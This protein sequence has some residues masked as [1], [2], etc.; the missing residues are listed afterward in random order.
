[1]KH[2]ILKSLTVIIIILSLLTSGAAYALGEVVYTNTQKLADNL[3]YRNTISWHPTLGRTESFAI[4]MTG[5][6]DAYPIVMNGETVFGTNR[7]SA[8]VE[9]AE[10]MGK[11]VLAAV[12]ADFFFPQ[13]GGVPLGIVIEDGEYKSSP[14]GRNAVVFGYQG[15]VVILEAP[16][17]EISLYNNGGSEEAENAGQTAELIHFNKPRTDHGG[18]MLYSEAFSNT[19]TRTTTPGWFIRFRILEGTPSVSGVM[20]L[21]VTEKLTSED[22]I[23]IGEGNMVLTAADENNIGF[24]FEKFAVGDIVTLSTTTND[25]RLANAQYATGGGDVLVSRGVKADSSGW[26]P[27]LLPR[28]PRTAFG[29]RAD[30]SVVSFVVD[31]RNSVHSV[32]LTLDELADE[33]LRQGC[34][35]AVNFDGG[36]SS[37]LSIRIPGEKSARVVSRPS[38]GAE[39]GCA[40]YLLFVTDEIPGGGARNLSLRNDGIVVLAESTVE[41]EFSATD[42]GYMPAV[43]PVDIRVTS[44]DPGAFVDGTQYTAGSIAGVDVINLH[45]PFTGATGRG[46]V[47]VISRPTSITATRRG[48]SAPLTSVRVS[49]GEKLELDVTATYYRRDVTSQLHSFEFTVTGDIG[50]MVEPGV[51]VAGTIPW[52][53]GM[54]TISAGGRSVDVRVEIGGFSD[55]DNHWAR[56][57]AEFLASTG[58]TIGITPSEYGPEQL[59]RRGDYILMLYRAA[60]EP[61]IESIESFDDVPRDMYYAE[62]IAWALE[63]G[64]ADRLVANN[65]E[66]QSPLSR[67]HAFTFTY[68]ALDILDKNFTSGTAADIASFPDAGEVADFAVVP[69]ATLVNL[70]IVEGSNGM[71]IPDSTMTR[72]QMAK[73]ITMVLKLPEL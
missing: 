16:T 57:F 18:L 24:E 47:Y 10:S 34:V 26:T 3:E 66:P 48:L 35:Y 73:V 17:V 56:E 59:M 29:V 64:I 45:S 40:T 67:Q 70:G 15:G 4:R 51:F 23:E 32:G 25:V 52:E 62:A 44:L 46:E 49:P 55:M 63:A 27:A 2:R 39:R 20:T 42:G 65:F 58:I 9:L 41:L 5:R 54:I 53:I 50:E 36:G 12:N 68:R 28:A 72:A 31:G 14:G 33:M 60:G 22:A 30:G 13:H 11:N 21:E 1:M 19:S 61:E 43:V 37:A 69:T 8:M 71:L 7:I 6:G 38:D